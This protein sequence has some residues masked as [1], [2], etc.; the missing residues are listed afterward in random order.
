MSTRKTNRDRI[1]E[2]AIV[3]ASRDGLQGLTIGTLA[4][5]LALSKSGVFAHFKSKD[6]LQHEV[7]LAIF[8][9]FQREVIAPTLSVPHGKAQVLALFANWVAWSS[10][11]ERP[12][13]CPIA[14]AIFD[15]DA[16][17]GQVRDAIR[18]GFQDFVAFIHRMMRE[19]HA[20]DLDP[21]RTPEDLEWTMTGLYFAQHLQRYLLGDLHAPTAAIRRFEEYLG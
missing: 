20:V 2:Q 14:G 18:D 3:N 21:A 10:N 12:G 19:A 17:P 4:S 13:G 5:Q 9:A 6:A 11:P 15:M 8:N 1:V 16:H 7:V